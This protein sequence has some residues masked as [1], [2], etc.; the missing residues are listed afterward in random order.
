MPVS[1]AM[2]RTRPTVE[3]YCVANGER[4]SVRHRVTG[5]HHK[6]HRDALKMRSVHQNLRQIGGQLL[7]DCDAVA[8]VASQERNQFLQDVIDIQ[9]SRVPPP[10]ADQNP[11]SV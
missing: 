2:K 10:I 3:S 8:R 1:L 9:R 4:P 11:A 6:A 5:V 7:N